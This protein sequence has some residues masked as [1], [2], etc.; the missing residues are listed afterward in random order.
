[1][2]NFL[3]ISAQKISEAFKAFGDFFPELLAATDSMVPSAVTVQRA[4]KAMNE[5]N[6]ER[7]KQF[8][9]E[10]TQL[11]LMCDQSPSLDAVNMNGTVLKIISL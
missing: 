11:T 10:S 4:R 8:V 1:M 7:T 2:T 5:L 9:S 6:S 3:G